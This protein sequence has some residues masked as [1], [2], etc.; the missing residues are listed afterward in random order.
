[1]SFFPMFFLVFHFTNPRDNMSSHI[2][3]VQ[4]IRQM[5]GGSQA[6]LMRAS[7]GAYYVTKF[8][9]SPQG[10]RIL[11]NE[12]FASRLGL[13]LELPMAPVEVI[14]VSNWLIEN[15]PD[16]RIE[17]AGATI[18]CASGRQVGSRY[19]CDPLESCVFD[20]LPESLLPKIKNASDFIRT[21]VLDKWAGNCDGRQAVFSKKATAR[22]YVM[23]LIDQAYCFNAT[24]WNF[25]DCALRGISSRNLVYAGVTG[26]D[27]FEPTLSKAEQADLIDIWRC[28]EPIPPEW[29]GGD[30]SAL[31]QLVE[32]LNARRRK[33][34]DLIT[35]FRESPRNPFPNW[36]ESRGS[37]VTAP[38]SVS[39]Q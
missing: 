15:T 19:I 20:Y 31:E 34:R 22:L 5:R 1:M 12:F 16:L 26:W 10:T 27:A 13:W 38:C 4:H 21:L 17:V 24:E 28:A 35:A 32:T 3:A 36:K 39:A 6:Q 23:T 14:E 29:Y 8:Q 18:P 2:Q 37:S 33:I 9:N 11:A 7:D 25:P 30:T